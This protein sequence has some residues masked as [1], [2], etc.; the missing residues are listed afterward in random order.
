MPCA[1]IFSQCMKKEDFIGVFAADLKLDYLQDMI[2]EYSNT[3]EK[4]SYHLLL[5]ERELL[6]HILI[7]YRLKNSIIIRH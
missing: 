4:E 2:K 7:V 3:Q 1:S 6:L 5:M